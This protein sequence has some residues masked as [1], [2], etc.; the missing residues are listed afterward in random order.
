MSTISGISSA[1]S[2]SAM[3]PSGDMKAKM[4]AKVDSDGS[5]GVDQSEL[6]S[7]LDN[8]AKHSGT[9]GTSSTSSTS[10]QDVFGK[11]DSNGDGSLDQSELD[12]GMK[13]L[14]PAPTSTAAFAQSRQGGGPEGS[15]GPPPPPPPDA[16]ES[17]GSSTSASSDSSEVDPLDTNK[18]GVVSEQER[19]AGEVKDAV[20]TLLKAM[21]TDGDKKISSSEFDNFKQMLTAAVND[22]SS[23]SGS[24]AS[25]ASPG[26]QGKPFD[27]SSLT[28][29]V[30]KEYAKA[31]ST[32]SS[33]SVGSTL[34]VAA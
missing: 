1:S 4:F 2:W 10:A 17:T 26:G 27:L 23:S 3:R 5:G 29:M 12:Q 21:D 7:M 31:A 8:I 18:D 16:A 25:D 11:M 28:N 13:S 20:K 9:S 22:A 15:G 19:A 24:S 6:Q 34:S 30:L 33:Q 14:M 32:L